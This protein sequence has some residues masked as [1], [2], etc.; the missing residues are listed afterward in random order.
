MC[1]G[2]DSCY[3]RRYTMIAASDVA[4]AVAAAGGGRCNDAAAGPPVSQTNDHHLTVQ[5]WHFGNSNEI[6]LLMYHPP[7]FGSG[8]GW[9]GVKYPRLPPHSGGWWGACKILLACY[10]YQNSCYQIL[11]VNV[12]FKIS[13]CF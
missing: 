6:F 9:F 8:G 1:S 3:R 5:P 2:D 12:V 11:I 10:N 4:V 13:C 7:L